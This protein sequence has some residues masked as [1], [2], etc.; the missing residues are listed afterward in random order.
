MVLEQIGEILVGL[1]KLLHQRREVLRLKVIHFH[2]GKAAHSG[3]GLI[4][5]VLAHLP[6]VL[7]ALGGPSDVGIVDFGE[8]EGDPLAGLTSE[9]RTPHDL[10][11]DFILHFKGKAE[12]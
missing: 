4:G 11:R 9:E 3:A 5:R 7:S 12:P 1:P 2:I 6:D 8:Q 10:T